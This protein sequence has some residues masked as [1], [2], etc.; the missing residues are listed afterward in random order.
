MFLNTDKYPAA[1]AYYWVMEEMLASHPG[2][3]K[4]NKPLHRLADDTTAKNNRKIVCDSTFNPPSAA[5]G[6]SC[7]EY[8][9]A[10]AQES[11]GMTLTSGNACVQMYATQN[12]DSTYT[13][14]LDPNYPYPTWQEVCGR[15]AITVSQ[16]KAAGGSLGHFTTAVRLL[17]KDAY[18]VHT[19]FENCTIDEV[20]RIT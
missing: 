14:N 6:K 2:S 10:R 15:A 20:C 16:N 13:L 4:H 18:F 11:G 17:D 9:F 12:P 19:G 3:K 8:P 5:I 1:A 7:D